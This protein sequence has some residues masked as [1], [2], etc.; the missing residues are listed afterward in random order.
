MVVQSTIFWFRRDLRLHDHPALQAAIDEA[1]EGSVLPLFVV[2]PALFDHAGPARR[3]FLLSCLEQLNRDLDGKLVLRFGQPVREVPKLAEEIGAR[4]VFVTA[5]ATPNGVRRDEV[6]ATALAQAGRQL[7]QVGSCYLN[8]PGSIRTG[9]GGRYKVFTPYWNVASTLPVSPPL[10]RSQGTW[11]TAHS[12]VA[13]D[14]VARRP[15]AVHPV[16]DLVEPQAPPM[17]PDGGEAAAHQRLQR[18]LGVVDAYDEQRDLPADDA[19]SRLSVDL[20]F[21]TLH[22]RQIVYAIGQGTSGRRAFLRQLGWRDFY[23]DVLSANPTSAWNDLHPLGIDHDDDH[24]AHQRFVAW[25]TGMTGF[26]LVDA[27][28]RQLLAEGFMHNRVRMIAASFLVKD[29]HLPWQWGA[30]WFLHHLV[31]GDLAS[32]SH[33]WQWVAGVGTDASPYFRVFNPTLQAKRFDPN[34][35]YVQRWIPELVGL[36][37]KAKS[38]SG[39]LFDEVQ[40]RSIYPEPIVD[41][42]REREEAIRR[43]T[44]ANAS[45]KEGAHQ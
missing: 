43:L 8:P 15:L 39:T 38:F 10:G 13:L 22:P 40:R 37:P 34:S 35:A 28:M 17:L 31:D 21:G 30:H 11:S 27:G 42:A 4:S 33:G 14:E 16:V 1:G 41:H 36:N 26:P 45:V 44:R 19:T 7:V 6:V 20:H 3:A 9:S 2:D 23:A 25:A 12:S 18:F 24:E 32:N 29:L 5:D